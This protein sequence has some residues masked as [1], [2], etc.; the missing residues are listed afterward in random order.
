MCFAV[1]EFKPGFAVLPFVDV[2]ELLISLEA[3]LHEPT[4]ERP[5]PRLT[6][7]KIEVGDA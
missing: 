3:A 5:A 2:H 6:N 7:E 4:Q 1:K